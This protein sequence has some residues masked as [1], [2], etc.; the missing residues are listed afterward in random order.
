MTNVWSEPPVKGEER[1]KE[2]GSIKVLHPCQKP[3]RL[4]KTC[5]EASS[6]EGDVIWEPFGG[7]CTGMLA[8]I[9][10]K[11][12]AFGAEVIP[13]FYTLAAERLKREMP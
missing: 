6:D 3:L 5:I 1:L 4:N 7:L 10:L 2:K 11:R 13:E 8:S 9:Q 12:K